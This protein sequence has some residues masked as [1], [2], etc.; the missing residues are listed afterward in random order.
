[1]VALIDERTIEGTLVAF[2]RT[3]NLL[4]RGAVER[5]PHH[6]RN[7]GNMIIPLALVSDVEKLRPVGG[8]EAPKK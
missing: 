1:V 4:M 3:G 6:S 7:V 5:G 2:E 8:A